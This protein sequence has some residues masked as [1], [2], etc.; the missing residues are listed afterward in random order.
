[1]KNFKNFQV[2][3]G[4]KLGDSNNPYL[5]RWVLVL[6]GYSIRLHHWVGSDDLRAFHCHAWDFFTFVLSGEYVD[7]NPQGE[8]KL[9]KF[10]LTFR[11]AEHKHSVYVPNECW[12]LLLTGRPKRKWG[13]YPE[14]RKKPIR[15]LRYFSKYGH[16]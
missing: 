6:F 7:R 11:R 5:V 1:M 4:E 8:E 10:S 16:H 14:N 13:F 12:T 3:F 15:P 9:D 2:R